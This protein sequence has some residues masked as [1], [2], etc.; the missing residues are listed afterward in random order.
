MD[1]VASPPLQN[2]ALYG[3]CV[4][5]CTDTVANELIGQSYVFNP[6]SSRRRLECIIC[7]IYTSMEACFGRGVARLG[8]QFYDWRGY[9]LESR[10]DKTNQNCFNH[11]HV[12]QNLVVRRVKRSI[13]VTCTFGGWEYKLIKRGVSGNLGGPLVVGV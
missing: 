12:S 9:V 7:G 13:L 2:S 10:T 11:F 8:R 3:R 4:N 5:S 6:E 1:I